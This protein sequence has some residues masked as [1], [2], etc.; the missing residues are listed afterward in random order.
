MGVRVCVEES[1]PAA[2]ADLTSFPDGPPGESPLALGNA[3]RW[4]SGTN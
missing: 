2:G 4:V 3:R 1:R